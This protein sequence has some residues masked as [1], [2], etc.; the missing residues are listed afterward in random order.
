MKN[1][2]RNKQRFWY[3]IFSE[4]VPLYDKKGNYTGEKGPGYSEPISAKGN[5]SPNAGGNDF[6]QFGMS[7]DYDKTICLDGTDW[8]I[9][10]TS[11]LF[12]DKE[13]EFDNKNL[14][15]FDYRIKKIAKSLNTTMIAIQ[16]V[17]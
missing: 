14:P 11:V 6:P 10:E 1:L 16:K 13:P 3:C 2:E 17:R 4:E 8:D 9:Q 12:V 7:L 5:I 15:K